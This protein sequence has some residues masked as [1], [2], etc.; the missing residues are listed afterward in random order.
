[1]IGFYLIEWNKMPTHILPCLGFLRFP[2]NSCQCIPFLHQGIDIDRVASQWPV[3][4]VNCSFVISCIEFS[5]CQRRKDFGVVRIFLGNLP[6]R[7]DNFRRF[8]FVYPSLGAYDDRHDRSFGFIQLPDGYLT[9]DREFG[10]YLKIFHLPLP[11][12]NA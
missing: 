9:G 10:R 8:L 3:S 1:M 2:G 7:N 11:K 5:L 4:S 12:V 6:C